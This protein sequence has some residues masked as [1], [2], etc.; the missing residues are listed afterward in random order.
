MDRGDSWDVIN[1]F[2]TFFHISLENFRLFF[3][4]FFLLPVG[5]NF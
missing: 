5:F 4:F 2:G 3:D 1:V